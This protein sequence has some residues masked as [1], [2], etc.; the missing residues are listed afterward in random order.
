[1]RSVE[2]I[3]HAAVFLAV[4]VALTLATLY[5]LAVAPF[6]G[7]ITHDDQRVRIGSGIWRLEG[8]PRKGGRA[9]R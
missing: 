4:L 8:W 5:P 3:G 6:A 7:V 2:D 1:M 9:A